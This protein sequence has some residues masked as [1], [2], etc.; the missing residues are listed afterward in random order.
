LIE[1]GLLP[2]ISRACL[3]KQIKRGVGESIFKLIV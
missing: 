1:E 2:R 3:V